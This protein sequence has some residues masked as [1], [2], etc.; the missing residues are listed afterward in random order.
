[1]TSFTA[2]RNAILR[3]SYALLDIQ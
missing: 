3:I 1:M 2:I